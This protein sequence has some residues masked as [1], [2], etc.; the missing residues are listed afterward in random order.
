MKKKLY[1]GIVFLSVVI[2]ISSSGLMNIGAEESMIIPKNREEHFELL[3]KLP[4]YLE[5]T[6]L[7]GSHR[8]V[9]TPD[10]KPP[11]DIKSNQ[12]DYCISYSEAE[13]ISN[14]S[15]INFINKYGLDPTPPEPTNISLAYQEFLDFKESG[16]MKFSYGPHEMY[17][18]IV[19]KV[20]TAGDSQNRPLDPS[21][22]CSCTK[23]GFNRFNPAFQITTTYYYYGY[24]D[25]SDV[26]SG[27]IRDYYE[28]LE[29]DCSW[30]RTQDN[31]VIFGWIRDTV[32]DTG[33]GGGFYACAKENTNF[34][35]KGV[36]QHEI[37]H[38]YGAPDHGW[39]IF[40]VCVMSYFYL[41]LGHDGWC[42]S[43]SDTIYD[44]IWEY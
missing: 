28:D 17:G 7:D 24:W 38:C 26:S 25:A 30:L 1:I 2:L 4:Y 40:D 12:Y 13:Q 35:Y 43:C 27:E 37:S 23:S 11:F 34:P 5:N 33:R 15:K 32:D 44:N 39:S 9:I 31:Q 19:T 20:I 16:S 21:N 22:L 42:D 6:I 8:V 10:G 36:A 41:W 3:E 18:M 29:D 14:E